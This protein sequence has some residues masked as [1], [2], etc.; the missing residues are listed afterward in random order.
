MKF[1]L[2]RDQY[3]MIDESAMNL[4]K[5]MLEINPNQRITAKQAL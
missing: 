3:N 4:L 1:D 5:K 2:D